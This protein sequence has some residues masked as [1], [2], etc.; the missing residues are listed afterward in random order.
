MNMIAQV[1]KQPKRALASLLALWISR[2]EYVRHIAGWTYGNI[3]RLPITAAFPGIDAVDITILRACDRNIRVSLH[4][5]ELAALTA[6]VRFVEADSI[7]EIGTYRGNT[8]LNLAANT[9]ADAR[10]T[11]VDIASDWS[12]RPKLQIPDSYLN[13]ASPSTIGTQYINTIYA[14]KI[15][16]L[17]GD[18]TTMDWSRMP[19]PFD[20]V[21]IDGCHHY[22]YVKK[23]TE[24]SMMVLKP[25]GLLV[26]H[27]Y[28]M[29]RHV[30]KVVDETAEIIEVR[31]I[32]GTR[33]A[34]GFIP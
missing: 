25:G 1:I 13:V 29:I 31:A 11:T 3:H 34:V 15:T 4:I 7:L 10:I 14:K 2:D 18:S 28:G 9:S 23:D 19:S 30:S 33:L 26:W 16:Q 32:E 27:D 24:N 12:D 22:T 6:I 21:F 8:T 17:L 5:Q 20:M